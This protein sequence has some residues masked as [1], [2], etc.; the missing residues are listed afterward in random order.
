MPGVS[1]Q[2]A[3]RKYSGRAGCHRGVRQ[4]PVGGDQGT[5]ECLGE[6]DVVG[7]YVDSQ[8]AR[9]LHHLPDRES[10][11]WQRQEIVDSTPEALI[12]EIAVPPSSSKNVDRFD[13]VV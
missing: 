12:G 11:D 9:S 13:A 7:D 5:V 10:G 8:L 1:K 2:A 6:R 3:D 4:A